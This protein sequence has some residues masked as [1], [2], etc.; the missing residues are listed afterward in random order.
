[1]VSCATPWNP[2]TMTMSLRSRAEVIRPGVMS[3]I[4][5]FP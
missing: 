3:M 4:R 1:L 2:A 5:A